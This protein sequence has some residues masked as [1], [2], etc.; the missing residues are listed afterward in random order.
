MGRAFEYRRASKEARWDK[1]SKLFPK[2]GKIITMAAKE[3]GSDPE[4]NTKL[5]TAILNAKVQ[6]MPKDNIEKAIKRA[7]GKDA[8]SY[9][10]AL[11][12]VKGP[13]GVLLFVE[14]ATDNNTR[15][16]NNVRTAVNKG[17]GQLLDSGALNFMFTRKAVVEF[18]LKDG[19]DLE[20]VE[21]A[22]IDAGLEELEADGKNALAYGDY[23]S[24]GTLSKGVEDLGL[25]LVKAEL[26]RIPSNAVEFTA[27]Q[28]EEIEVLIDK[29]EDD[30]DVQK[31]FSNIA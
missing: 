1:M 14:C 16:Y 12:E 24:F 23:K 2:L 26:Q 28:V 19:I 21:L 3:G 9:D 20:E 30:E 13:H 4:S 7:S 25:E 15:T 11:Y 5:R 27:E 10:E 6:N 22:L 17:G 29:L 31:V 8:T 18:T